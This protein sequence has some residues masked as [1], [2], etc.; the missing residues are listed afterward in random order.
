MSGE[1]TVH[2]MHFMNWV[3]QLPGTFI[4]DYDFSI[5]EGVKEWVM[6]GPK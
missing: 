3:R 4:G 6:K 1:E 2:Y 5:I